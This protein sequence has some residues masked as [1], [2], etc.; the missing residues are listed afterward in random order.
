MNF[1]ILGSAGMAGNTIAT[2]L[3]ENGHNV[4]GFSRKKVD[5]IITVEGDATN[6]QLLEKVIKEGG[7]DAV[8]NCVGILNKFAEENPAQAVFLNSYLPHKLVELTKNIDT[9][10]IHISTD[11]V[12]SGKR[13]GYTENDFPDG[14]TF[15]DRTKALG[16][17]NDK[18]NVTLRNSIIGP[19]IKENGIGLFNW[20]MKQEGP[21]K[22]YTKAL[23]TGITTLELAKVIEAAVLEKATGLINMVYHEPINKFDLLNLFNKHLRNNTIKVEPFEGYVA[24]KS[25]VRTNFNFTYQVPSYE[26]MISEMA[27]W[28]RNH[29]EKYPHYKV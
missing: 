26:T 13:G 23:W 3:Q 2:Y 4:T 12:Y 16:E 1:L 25:L 5:E 22:G 20:F 19:D 6:E 11:C 10:V 7:Y 27:N 17:I 15:Y 18:K 28:I 24:D 29:K 8:V 9:K 14:K 21:I